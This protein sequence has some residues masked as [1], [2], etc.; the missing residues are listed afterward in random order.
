[1][2]RGQRT[3][4]SVDLHHASDVSGARVTP[5]A[6][7]AA[8]VVRAV[9]IS[10]RQL[11]AASMAAMPIC[12]WWRSSIVPREPSPASIDGTFDSSGAQKWVAPPAIYA[13][14]GFMAP[15]ATVLTDSGCARAGRG[16]HV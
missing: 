12:N 3:G 5:P 13:G 6:T 10:K 16:P 4:G 14:W 11:G 9:G 15:P 8:C 7:E 1:M 2:A